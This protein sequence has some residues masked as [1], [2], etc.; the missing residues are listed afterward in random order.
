MMLIISSVKGNRY[1]PFFV[2]TLNFLKSTQILNFPF[3]LSIITI[4][5]RQVASL[6]CLIKPT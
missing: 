5:D 2:T 3:F 4:N 1:G 6:T